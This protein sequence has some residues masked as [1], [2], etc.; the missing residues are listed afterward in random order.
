MDGGSDHAYA[1]STCVWGTA[2]EPLL[3]EIAGGESVDAWRVLDAGAGE[4][5]NTAYLAR[6]G[7]TVDA[8]EVSRLAVENARTTWGELP[9]VTWSVGDLREVALPAAHYDLVVLDS[10]LH[11]LADATDADRVLDRL[12]AATRPGG[13]HLMCAFDDRHQELDGHPVPPRF[14]PAHAWYVSRY[15]GWHIEMVRTEEIVSAHPGAPHPHA[16]SVTKL[17]ARRPAL[18]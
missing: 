14:I 9:G 17:V 11:W 4:G 6:H 12:R 15:D 13:R 7:A 2:P 18:D 3:E 10:V 5:R 16:H 1:A 8:I